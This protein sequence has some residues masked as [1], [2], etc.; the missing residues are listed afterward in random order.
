M[1]SCTYL[2]QREILTLTDFENHLSSVSEEVEA[3]RDSMGQKQQRMQELQQLMEDAAAHRE[4]KPVFDEMKKGKYRFAKTRE[5]YRAEHKGELR[6]FYM[7][8]RRLKEKGGE[9]DPFPAKAW[10]REFLELQH[11]GRPSIRPI[12]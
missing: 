11:S 4:L 9:Q 3:R 5:K 6:R 8:R 12:S 1:E 2:H 7:V 10:Q